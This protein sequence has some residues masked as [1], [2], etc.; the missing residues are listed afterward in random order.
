MLNSSS[1]N[2]NFKYI[3]LNIL[4]NDTLPLIEIYK[5]RKILHKVNGVDTVENVFKD[6]K[7]ILGDK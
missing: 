6:I 2:C 3:E 5:K 1:K 4:Y 7:N